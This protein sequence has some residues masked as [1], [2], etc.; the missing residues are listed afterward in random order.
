MIKEMH[1]FIESKLAVE[2]KSGATIDNYTRHLNEFCEITGIKTIDDFLSLKKLD[3]QK[4]IAALNL[5][6]QES[7]VVTKT[8]AV[9]S[10]YTYLIKDDDYPCTVNLMGKIDIGKPAVKEPT[11]PTKEDIMDILTEIKKN[12][13][14]YALIM[15]LASTGL[16]ISEALSIKVSDL[17][18]DRIKVKGK[19]NKERIIYL[20]ADTAEVIIDYAQN[21][22]HEKPLLSKEE[23]DAKGWTKFKSYDSYST[24]IIEGHEL[25]FISKTGIKMDTKSVRTTLR[26]YTEKAGVDLTKVQVSPHKLRSSFATREMINGTPISLMKGMLGHSN[27]NTTMRYFGASQQEKQEAFQMSFNFGKELNTRK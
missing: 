25:L 16:R 9:R 4:Y 26:S 13:T 20:N 17:Y 1:D 23:F 19:G 22:R 2:K 3:L 8:M 15:L 6:N 7:S 24:Q 12:K 14:Y 5:R 27:I 18:K 10:F 21:H 11:P